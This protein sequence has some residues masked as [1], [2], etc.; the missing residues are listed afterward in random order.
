MA[1][2]TKRGE[3]FLAQVRIKRAGAI[4]FSESKMFPTE[5]EAES[6][7]AR[8]EES[9]KKNGAKAT[10]SRGITVGDLLLNHL[11]YIQQFRD[12][13]RSAI[14]NYEYMATKFGDIQL[15]ALTSRD[16]IKFAVSR[17]L[18]GVAPSTIMA[19]LSTLSA[20][21]HAAPHAH[22][23]D[24][25]PEPIDTALA[26]LKGDGIAGRSREVVRI[27]SPEEEAALMAEFRRH[28]KHHQ[29]VIPMTQLF[30][31]ALA[32]PRRSSE[33]TRIRWADVD[34]KRRTVIIRDVKHP[35]H[36]IG[37][38]QVVPLLGQ[39]WEILKALPRL[40]ERIWPY[41]SDSV[42]AV[43]ERARDRIAAT[44]MPAIQDLRFH[45]LRHT[46]ITRLF[47]RGL[48]VAEVAVVSGHTNWTQLRRYTHIQ[49]DSLHKHF[50][51]ASNDPNILLTAQH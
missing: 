24:V 27:A 49:P 37:N 4:I 46:G 32:F 41:N 48:S 36:K 3:G 30:P 38:D 39:A 11:K 26:R 43:F 29:S 47:E 16:I 31:F 40:E 28:D 44:G 20:A 7:A 15:R 10:I 2:I 50:D 9:I 5:K 18:E 17:K 12:L 45:D 25:S 35:R 8:L 34:M 42:Q 33:L 22:D 19:N 21:L 6:W 14:Q 13:A 51:E 23:L 1:S